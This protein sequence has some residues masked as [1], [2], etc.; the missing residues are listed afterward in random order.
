M[1]VRTPVGLARPRRMLGQ[2]LLTAK[3]TVATAS[4][5]RVAA[6]VAVCVPDVVPVLLVERVVRHLVEGAAP[7]GEALLQVQADAL[8]EERVLQTAVV[9]EVSVATQRPVQVG[10]ACGEVL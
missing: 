3:R 6:D 2:N 10:H 8:E 7:E 4:P 9:L 1:P 5:V